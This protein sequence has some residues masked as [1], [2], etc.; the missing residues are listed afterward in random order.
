MKKIFWITMMLCLTMPLGVC[1]VD[2]RNFDVDK[3]GDVDGE[4][5][6]AFSQYFGKSCW[7][8][9]FNGDGYSD[10]TKVWA[11]SRPTDYYLANELVTLYGDQNDEKLLSLALNF[12]EKDRWAGKIA[13]LTFSFRG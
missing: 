12:W 2:G 7:Y 8:K 6:A 3:D 4:E 9:D 13:P 1:A 11:I 5:L 10:G